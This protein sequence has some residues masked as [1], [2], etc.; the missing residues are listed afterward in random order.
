MIQPK[1]S[2]G[3]LEMGFSVGR[4]GRTILHHLHRKVPLLVQQA[5]YFDES[6]PKMPCVYILSAGGPT[7]EGDRYAVRVE[8]EQGAMAHISTGAATLVASMEGGDAE[9]LQ[10]ITLHE[11]SY[12]EWL[13]KPLIPAAHSRYRSSTE[14]IASPSASLFWSEVVACGR[15]HSGERF[16]YDRL[17]LGASVTT[18][19]GNTLL[20]ERLIVT[21]SLLSPDDYTL[22]G[23]FTHFSS[24]IILTPAEVTNRLYDAIRPTVEDTLRMSVARLDGHR[25]LVVRCVGMESERL[26]ALS[27]AL[28]SMVRKEIKGVELQKEFPWR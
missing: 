2:L 23:G 19:Q 14:I 16:D 26:V 27:R 8:L 15:L 21:P 9:M 3:L 22:M 6:L 1:G 5:L 17:D 12:L 13:P 7:V 24:A 11:G 28:C 20:R 10:R 18:H 4:E 25:G